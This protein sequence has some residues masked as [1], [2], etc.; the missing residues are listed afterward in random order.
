LAQAREGWLDRPSPFFKKLSDIEKF[1]DE[2]SKVLD[3]KSPET[4]RNPEDKLKGHKSTSPN[5]ETP[6]ADSENR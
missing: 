5:E 4:S 6:S 3:E 2:K 1:L